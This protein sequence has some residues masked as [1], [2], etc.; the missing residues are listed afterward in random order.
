MITIGPTRWFVRF[1]RQPQR[2][3]RAQYDLALLPEA[4][5]YLMS[6]VVYNGLDERIE[7]QVVPVDTVSVTA[8]L[9]LW[10]ANGVEEARL[11]KSLC[12]ELATQA[13]GEALRLQLFRPIDLEKYARQLIVQQGLQMAIQKELEEPQQVDQ[14]DIRTDLLFVIEARRL[15]AEARTREELERRAATRRISEEALKRSLDLLYENLPS[16][17]REEAKSHL[18]ITVVKNGDK[19]VIPVSN[20]GMV[21]RYD[22]NGEKKGKYCLVFK[23]ACLPA[24]DEALM[25]FILIQSDLRTF[26]SKANFF[27]N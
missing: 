17:L 23:D 6:K 20:H 21:E 19:W 7:E 25:K 16:D 5:S 1:S 22:K 15:F 14:I 27:P 26:I 9:N 3:G 10:E 2:G 18:T 13:V 24:G 12:Q 4:K 11:A 8:W